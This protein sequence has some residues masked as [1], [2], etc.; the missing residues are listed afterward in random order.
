MSFSGGLLKHHAVRARAA[1]KQSTA[2]C[3]AGAATFAVN[4]HL[5]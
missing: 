1:H 2:F 4:P 3:F 5:Y